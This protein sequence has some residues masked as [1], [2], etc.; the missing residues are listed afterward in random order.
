MFGNI[1]PKHRSS[2][3]VI[4]LLTLVKGKLIDEYGIDEMLKPFVESILQLK[5]VFVIFI[6]M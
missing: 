1:E 5:Q 2:L 6:S 3:R 4:Q